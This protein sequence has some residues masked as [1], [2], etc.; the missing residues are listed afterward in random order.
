[1][2]PRAK[3]EPVKA[4]EL[5]L[6]AL[7]HLPTGVPPEPEPWQMKPKPFRRPKPVIHPGQLDLDGNEHE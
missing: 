7:E 2:R 6:A 1:M 5:A 3:T 4:V